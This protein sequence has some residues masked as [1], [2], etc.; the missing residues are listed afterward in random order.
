MAKRLAGRGSLEGRF[1]VPP[2]DVLI[3]PMSD[4]DLL[5]AFGDA[6]ELFK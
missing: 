4:E 1:P 5:E 2:D 6:A 3:G